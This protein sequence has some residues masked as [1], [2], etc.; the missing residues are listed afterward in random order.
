M[1]F[2]IDVAKQN[3]IDTNVQLHFTWNKN[4]IKINVKATPNVIPESN[5]RHTCV[6]DIIDVIKKGIHG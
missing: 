3:A 6:N 2:F 4:K 1:I 5:T